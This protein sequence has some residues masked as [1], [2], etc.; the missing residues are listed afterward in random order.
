MPDP[1]PKTSTLA[2]IALILAIACGPIGALVGVIALMQIRKS[3]GQLG[4]EGLAIAS[5]VM[6]VVFFFIAGILAAI[7]IPNFVRYKMRSR[8]AEP[9]VVLT[10][11]NAGQEM[12]AMINHGYVAAAPT[13]GGASDERGPW[14]PAACA[15]ACK[16]DV[17]ACTSFACLSFDMDPGG[18]YFRY[19][20]ATVGGEA[21]DFT[22]AAVGDLDGDGDKS[23]FLFGSDNAGRGTI[24]APVP[25][26]AKA[27]GCTGQGQPAG[28]VVN[29]KP[30]AF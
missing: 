11:V 19:A 16:A 23:V 5:I 4:G 20:C 10:Q 21:D 18:T 24:V 8:Q 6:S 9:R 27:A 14:N 30:K 28:E 29:C 22:C 7:A 26:I 15:D 25:A 12:F 17:S 1:K 2:I 13:G 3:Q